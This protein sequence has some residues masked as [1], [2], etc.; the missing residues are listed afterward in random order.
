MGSVPVGAV[1]ARKEACCPSG[2]ASELKIEKALYPL[3]QPEA[4]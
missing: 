1:E 2:E 3:A 4:E